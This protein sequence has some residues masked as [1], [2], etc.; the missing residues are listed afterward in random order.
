MRHFILALLVTIGVALPCSAQS[1]QL[2]S[3]FVSGWIN[4][5]VWSAPATYYKD[6]G[7]VYLSGMIIKWP[8][9]GYFNDYA[10]VLPVGFRPQYDE[11]YLAVAAGGSGI[12][13]VMATGNVRV[14]SNSSLWLS[15]SGINFLAAP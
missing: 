4:G 14:T 2:V 7:R 8:E 10:F 1:P 13:T 5:S 12:I 15:L 11:R 6:G 9:S 3:E